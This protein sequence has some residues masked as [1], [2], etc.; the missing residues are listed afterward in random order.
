MPR[1]D[2]DE[3]R[4]RLPRTKI[5]RVGIPHADAWPIGGAVRNR[6]AAH[7]IEDDSVV[8]EEDILE[9]ETFVILGAV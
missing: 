9:R 1:L 8:L 2:A 6:A 5:G 7:L 3:G 4:A